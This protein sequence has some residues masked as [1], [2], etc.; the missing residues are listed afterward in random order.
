MDKFILN[1]EKIKKSFLLPDGNI[2]HEFFNYI[3]NNLINDYKISYLFFILTENGDISDK[4]SLMKLG[5]IMNIYYIYIDILYNLPFFLNKEITNNNASVHLIFNDTITVLGLM[6]FLNTIMKIKLNIIKDLS[7]N[8]NENFDEM[9][10]YLNNI[11]NL[12]NDLKSERANYIL[13]EGKERKDV[14]EDLN[15]ENKKKYLNSLIKY[16]KL[17]NKKIKPL[18]KNDYSIYD[19][20]N[21]INFEEIKSKYL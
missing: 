3:I 9:Y 7:I 10:T 13:S 12:M 2:I 4:D 6:F 5:L 17:F 14:L 16:T 18:E 19:E 11:G 8:K 15:I 20:L 21:E 1:V